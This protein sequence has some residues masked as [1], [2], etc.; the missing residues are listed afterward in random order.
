MVLVVTRLSTREF[1]NIDLTNSS[2]NVRVVADCLIDPH[3]KKLKK[4]DFQFYHQ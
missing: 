4:I 3:T 1:Q 2:A